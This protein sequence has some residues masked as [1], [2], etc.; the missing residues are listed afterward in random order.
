MTLT[1][2][3]SHSRF[4]G[5]MLAM[6]MLHPKQPL[7][8]MRIPIPPLKD[9]ELLIRI[10]A[11][12]VC[13]TDLHI[14]DGELTERHL[15]LVLGHE[16]VGEVVCVG[17][18]SHSFCNGDRVGVPWLGHTCGRCS[19][20]A[21][22]DENLCD[23]P[24]FT[25]YDRDGG[26][27]EY[28]AAD[29]RYCF[30]IPDQYDDLHAAPLMCGGLIGYRAYSMVADCERL[31]LYGFGAAAHIVAQIAVSQ[32]KKVYA[33]TRE[34]DIRTQKFALSL[35]ATWAGGSNLKPPQQLDAAIIFAPAGELV[36]QALATTR[37]GATVICAGIHMSDIPR[38]P[39]S[40]LWGERSIHSVANLTRADGEAFFKI[41]E[42]IPLKISATRYALQ[43][44]N[45]ALDD[46]RAGRLEGAAVLMPD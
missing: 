17:S 29:A 21:N 30:K 46:L 45:L 42:Q 24:E 36:P 12:G 14:L 28:I 43:D 13:R 34:D 32:G 3:T 33:F 23:H 1:Q 27:A 31:G 5:T 37:K 44:A 2:P 20:C 22:G 38:F 6:R 19:Y 8:A 4:D 35:G 39:Y 41:A 10:K 9:G 16:V 7:K 40:L 11:C 18:G 26:Y 15:P 25:G